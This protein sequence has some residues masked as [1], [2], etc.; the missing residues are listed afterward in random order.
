VDHSTDYVPIILII[1][2][3]LNVAYLLPIPILALMPPPAK[4]GTIPE[5]A[6]YKR[7]GGAHPLTVAAPVFTAFLCLLLFFFVG[8]ISEFLEP[9]IG[10]RALDPFAREGLLP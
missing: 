8:P 10:T 5:S 9:T 7:P 2:S 3:L 1:S 4:D 6:P